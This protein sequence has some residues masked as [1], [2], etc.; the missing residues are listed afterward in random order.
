[1]SPTGKKYCAREE[2]YFPATEFRVV[3]GSM[4]HFCD[5]KDDEPHRATDGIAV[6][7]TAAGQLEEHERDFP[8]AAETQRD[9]T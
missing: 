2:D 4:I 8:A 7:V 3:G 9:M 6:T 5:G 1:M